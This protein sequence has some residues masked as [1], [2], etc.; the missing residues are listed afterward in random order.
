METRNQVVGSRELKTRLGTYLRLVRN[1]ATVVVTER[2]TPIAEL[3]PLNLGSHDL[4]S[5]LGELVARGVLGGEIRQR[6]PLGEFEAVRATGPP[7]SST[8]LEDR[9]DRL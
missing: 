9:E 7:L 1:G 6:P 8:I 4:D 3:R 5:A 2:G